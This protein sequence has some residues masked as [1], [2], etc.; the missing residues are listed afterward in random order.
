MFGCLRIMLFRSVISSSKRTP[1]WWRRSAIER[2]LEPALVAVVER[3]EERRR[4]GD[5][6]QHRHVQPRARL[7]DRIELGIVHL[8]P[9]CRSA[10]FTNMPRSL[11]I[12]RPI[13]PALMSSSS[14]V[15]AFAP[16][17]GPTRRRNRRS[18]TAPSG[19][20]TC[21]ALI[22]STPCCSRSP[23][24]AAQVDEDLQVVGRPSPFIDAVELGRRDRRRLV[25]VD[26][27]DRDTSRAAP[28]AAAT[29]SVRLR[30]VLADVGG[31]NSGS[32]PSAGRGRICPAQLLRRRSASGRRSASRRRRRSDESKVTRVVMHERIAASRKPNS[33][34]P[35]L[36]P[37]GA[38]TGVTTIPLAPPSL[39]GS[40]D[41]PGG[42]GRAVPSS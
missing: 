23:Y 4:L 35:S 39:A 17:P 30:L 26:V 34:P 6:N 20:C 15:A 16:K 36:A 7:P 41:L 31:L 24:D 5:V 11:K 19:P 22:A 38:A 10:F 37:C 27:D 1:V 8:Q 9:R 14:C 13:A 12:F 2:E 42:F 32:R 40:S 21:C 18:R 29:T 25:A 3:L 28:G 33:V